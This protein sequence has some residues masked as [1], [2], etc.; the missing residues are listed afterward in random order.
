MTIQIS[1]KASNIEVKKINKSRIYRLLF[2]KMKLSK[3]E[4][5]TQLNISLPTVTRNLTAMMAEELIC[6]GGT[7]ESTGGRKAKVISFNNAAR[8]AIGIDVTKNDIVL[9]LIDLSGTVITSQRLK[10]PFSNTDDYFEKI[11]M[12]V[13]QTIQTH[14][15]LPSKVLGVGIAVPAIISEDM[16]KVAY[17]TVF[18]FSDG[19]RE[20][21]SRFIPYPCNLC[22][23][24][25]AGGIAEMWNNGSKKTAFYLSLSRSVGGSLLLS[26]KLYPGDNQRSC[27]VGHMTI[28]PDGRTC[29]CGK[30]GCVDAYCNSNILSRHCGGSLSD[31][32]K[33]IRDGNTEFLNI[34]NEYLHHL[35]VTINNIRMLFDS[36]VILG[37]YV[38]VYMDEYVGLLRDMIAQRNTFET[39]GTYLQ[40]CRYKHEAT[41]VGAAIMYIEAFIKSI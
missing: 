24:A 37:G 2:N 25:N 36:Q 41:A 35:A 17:A 6:E 38:G 10:I 29:Y 1:E 23:D 11:G 31:F 30:K 28:V 19:T 34:W 3:Q 20:H 14:Y 9:V 18:D 27:E 33:Q 15:I 4:I 26:N 39:D 40:P 5:A 16:Q 32:Y 21:F 8:Y 12:L 13:E 7:F 22:N